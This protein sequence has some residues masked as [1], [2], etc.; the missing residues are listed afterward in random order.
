MK[1]SDLSPE[2]VQKIEERLFDQIINKHE[3]PETWGTLDYYEFMS[4]DH[5]HLLLPIDKEHHANIT[6]RRCIISRDQRFLTIFLEDKT[7]DDG[8]FAGR[9]A[10]CERFDSEDFFITNLYHECFIIENG[11]LISH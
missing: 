4:F 6:I 5:H 10:V 2:V 9:I 3:G 1:V 7:Y 8:I 11:Q